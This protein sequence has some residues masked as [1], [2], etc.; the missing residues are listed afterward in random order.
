MIIN[1]C[2]I[3]DQL[4]YHPFIFKI[5]IET[6]FAVYHSSWNVLLSSSDAGL[7]AIVMLGWGQ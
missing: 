3:A 6:S 2:S 1:Y 7:G 5:G 4:Q